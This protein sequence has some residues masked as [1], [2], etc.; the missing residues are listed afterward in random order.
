MMK[1]T[2]FWAAAVAACAAVAGSGGAAPAVVKVSDFGFDEADSTRF[3]QAAL[4]SRAKRVVID[5]KRWV[6]LPL[7]CHGEQEIFF[8][9]GAV[10]EAKKGAFLGKS[11]TLFTAAACTNLTIGGKGEIRMHH[12]D[13]L[14]PPYEK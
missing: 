1:S 9:D 2:V 14:K 6:S 11:D 5:A 13:Y 8:E 12:D 3:L 10:V 4:D 7:R